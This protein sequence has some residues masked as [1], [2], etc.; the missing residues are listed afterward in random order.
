M[1][2]LH[3]LIVSLI[4]A[5]TF[6]RKWVLDHLHDMAFYAQVGEQRGLKG[7]AISWRM[8]RAS[9][10][11]ST[12]YEHI[13]RELALHQEHMA[14]LKQELQQAQREYHRARAGVHGLYAG[15]DR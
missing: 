3:T 15:R 13:E 11:L 14:L 12:A 10:G 7:L 1:N 9:K 8:W 4:G 2:K 5:G 6:A